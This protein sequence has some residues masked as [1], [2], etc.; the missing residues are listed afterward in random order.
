MMHGS[1]SDIQIWWTRGWKCRTRAAPSCD[2]FNRG[3]SYL[4]VTRTTVLHLFCPL[5]N[6]QVK[7]WFLKLFFL[8]SINN[9]ANG[10]A[11][12]QPRSAGGAV[13][14]V[15][16]IRIS[17][18]AN[19]YLSLMIHPSNVIGHYIFVLSVCLYVRTC[20]RTEAFSDRLAAERLKH[21]ATV[22]CEIWISKNGINVK[23]VF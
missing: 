16:C 13:T 15:I 3:S 19:F 6:H 21:V 1:E 20:A 18:N 22:P 14:Y 4:N 9:L 12:V 8:T 17:W 7:I 5:T 10:V 11:F 2:I 23:Y